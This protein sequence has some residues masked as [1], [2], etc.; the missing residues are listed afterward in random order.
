MH[1]TS[2]H[3]Q[4]GLL[5]SAHL[6]NWLVAAEEPT[7]DASS[8]LE[9]ARRRLHGREDLERSLFRKA[10]TPPWDQPQYEPAGD[11]ECYIYAGDEN[12]KWCA[13]AGIE[14][15][16]EYSY[17][18]DSDD[19]KCS[20]CWC[21]RREMREI[22][23]AP[24]TTF[25]STSTH[26]CSSGT[27]GGT[28]SGYDI[29]IG[30]VTPAVLAG[31][32]GCIAE[33]SLTMNHGDE[34]SLFS[35][36]GGDWAPNGLTQLKLLGQQFSFTVDL[37]SVGCACNL[38]LYLIS[39]PALGSDG[40]TSA[41]S[42]RDGQPPYYCDA[43]MVGG[44]CPEVDI[45]EANAATFQATPHRCDAPANSHY[46]NCDGGGCAQ[47]TREQGGAY[48]PGEDNTIDTRFPFDVVTEFTAEGAT[49]TGMITRLRQDGREVT[50]AHESCSAEYFAALSDAMAEGM[51]LRITYW[52]DQANTMAWMDQPPCG[53]EACS[54]DNAGAGIISRMSVGPIGTSVGGS[55]APWA[56]YMHMQ[57]KFFLGL[58]GRP[59]TAALAGGRL[60]RSFGMLLLASV[61]LVFAS[62]VGSC[63]LLAPRNGWL[64]T[65]TQ[66]QS[67]RA[68]AHRSRD[69]AAH[70]SHCSEK[71]SLL[72]GLVHR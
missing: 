26:Y 51:S 57:K 72:Y 41:G 62:L 9:R 59:L 5:L 52:G 48:G 12:G 68:P 4:F 23:Q 15:G 56:M 46:S 47:N 58:G 24:T 19:S 27:S 35:S 43:N 53:P 61:M 69:L 30:G 14:A 66:A 13:S 37:S 11:W 20:P 70:S 31:K 45:M 64:W 6:A 44:Q 40:S 33:D 8:M 10:K 25:T 21:C 28:Y 7:F 60:E 67:P 50:L 65:A 55:E 71:R 18:E 54:G 38:A 32:G 34:F 1:P 17:A 16:F 49:L 39:S 36:F 2:A 63:G 42:N 22:T 29:Q 3:R